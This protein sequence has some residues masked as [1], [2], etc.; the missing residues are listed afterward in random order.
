MAAGGQETA[1]YATAFAALTLS[2]HEGRLSIYSRTP[3][4]LPKDIEK[5]DK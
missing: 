4:K 2:V 5:K 1:A 3:P